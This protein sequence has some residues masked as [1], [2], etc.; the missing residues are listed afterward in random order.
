MELYGLTIDD[1]LAIEEIFDNKNDLSPVS[2]PWLVRHHMTESQRDYYAN[3]Q[4]HKGNDI[5]SIDPAPCVRM[6]VLLSRINQNIQ[7]IRE[8]KSKDALDGIRH[9]F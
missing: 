1:Q 2:I 3:Y 5:N 4:Y 6:D 8:G 7:L 9:W